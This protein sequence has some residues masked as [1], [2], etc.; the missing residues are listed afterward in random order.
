MNKIV[1]IASELAIITGHNK[2]QPLQKVIDSV[3]NR[4][5]IKKIHIP[6]SNIEA[7]LINLSKPDLLKIKSEL[8]LD[9][10]SS[11][12]EVETKI[13]QK[14]I[15]KSLDKNI[16]ENTSR[17]TT[18][19]V[20]EKM[21]ELK[22]CLANN[23]SQDLRMKRGN[24][25]ENQNLDETEKKFNIKI[26]YR[27]SK[28]YEKMVHSDLE[29]NYTIFL[30]GK[31]DGMNQDCVVE[32][33]NRTKRLFNRIPDYEK[34]QLNCYMFM[35]DKDR[36]IHIECYNDSQNSVEYDFDDD[37]WEE[38]KDKIIDFTDNHIVCHID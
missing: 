15:N 20:L 7:G 5:K 33:K 3:L 11:L 31:V 6:K 28:M 19:R 17:T 35:T 14:V 21:P 29:K 26:D 36:S 27:N 32:T 38:C 24:V 16:T 37:L 9:H 18:Q 13:R 1:I 30:R 34:I 2:Y 10:K 25:K 23:I 22:K 8:N 4:S 12:K